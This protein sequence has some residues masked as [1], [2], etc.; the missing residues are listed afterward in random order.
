MWQELQIHEFNGR[1][2]KDY[3]LQLEDLF[4]F[5]QLN[6]EEKLKVAIIGLDD[7]ARRWFE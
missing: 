3:V 4:E 6:E 5:F 2:S 7:E 1:N